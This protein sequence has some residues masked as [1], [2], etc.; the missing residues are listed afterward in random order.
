MMDAMKPDFIEAAI[1][2]ASEGEQA[3]QYVATCAKNL[4]GYACK[5]DFALR[6]R[7]MFSN[8]Y[9]SASRKTLQQDSAHK[10]LRLSRSVRPAHIESLSNPY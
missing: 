8:L 9:K 6:R 1:Y 4:C 5:S 2:I 3:G 10:E 7:W